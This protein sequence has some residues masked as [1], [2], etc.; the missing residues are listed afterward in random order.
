[1]KIVLVWFVKKPDI[2]LIARTT[3]EV[4]TAV[5]PA[6]ENGF[7]L[8]LVVGAAEGECVFGPDDEG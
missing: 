2:T 1:M 6:I 3:P 8:A 5:F 4:I 7:I